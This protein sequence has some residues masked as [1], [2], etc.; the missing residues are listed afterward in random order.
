MSDIGTAAADSLKVFDPN[1]P[2][3]EAD[4]NLVG[5]YGE[6]PCLPVITQ[7]ENSNL[8]SERQLGTKGPQRASLDEYHLSFGL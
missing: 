4:I 1:R 7:T 2:I 6:Q 8:S 3:R 5:P